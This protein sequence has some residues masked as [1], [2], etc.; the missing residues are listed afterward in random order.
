VT[1]AKI[2]SA[3]LTAVFVAGAFLIGGGTPLSPKEIADATSKA[4][5]NAK[6]A[7]DN[8]AQAERSTR[9]LAEIAEDVRS[10]LESSEKLLQ[11]QLGLEDSSRVGADRAEA[12]ERDIAAIGRALANLQ[13]AGEA[14]S[15]ASGEAGSQVETLAGSA[16]DLEDEIA[17]LG[18]RFGRVVKESREL[19]RKARGFERL[20][21]PIP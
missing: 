20:G 12:L 8:T 1:P 15:S 21:D 16:T 19:N 13:R 17:A 9:A 3:A 18:R 10:Q 7:A 6:E 5:N 11:I 14:L 4:A 2:I